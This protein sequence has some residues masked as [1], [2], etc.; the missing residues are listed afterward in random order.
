MMSDQHVV[1]GS[2]EVNAGHLRA[3][4]ERIERLHEE[5]K[6]LADD[7]ADIYAEAKNSGFDTKVMREI[8]KIR[9]QDSDKRAEFEEIL[10]LYLQALGRPPATMAPTLLRAH[11][12]A[13][14]Q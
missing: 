4:I 9:G 8:V 2:E 5:K 3:F 11:A 6:S 14:T 7:I 12:S 13:A 10:D 1:S